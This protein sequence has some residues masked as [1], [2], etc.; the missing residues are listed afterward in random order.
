MDVT[1]ITAVLLA[2]LL[3]AGWNALVKISGDSFLTFFLFKVGAL[4]FAVVLLLFTG[5]PD[6]AA[7]PYLIASGL[8][9]LAYALFLGHAY[10]NADF[11]IVYPIARGVAPV[12][13]AVLAMVF[14]DERLS[15]PMLAGTGVVSLGI[16][17]L[18]FQ[19][20][21]QRAMLSG[22]LSAAGVGATIA[23]YTLLD[24]IG[25]RLSGDPIAYMAL[26][27][28]ASF[29]PIC[30]VALVRR[31]SEAMALVAKEWRRGL[32]GGTLMYLAYGIVIYALAMA[33]MA[34]VSALR[35]T[36]VIIAAIIGTRLMKEPFGLRRVI[37]ATMVFAGV[38]IIIL[39]RN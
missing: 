35:E 25:A 38:A 9:L 5:V 20:R 28:I 19:R 24:G 4:P 14:A 27:N 17:L 15:G 1:L 30:A 39:A 34:S 33:P 10:Q 8:T 18:A 2:A 6:A 11:S 26:L 7:L 37:A 32:I 22:M 36:S 12:G 16:M 29:A 23:T 13:V 21:P 31:R 3:H